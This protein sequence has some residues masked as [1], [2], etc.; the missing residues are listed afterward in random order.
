MRFARSIHFKIKGGKETELKNVF[1]KEVVPLLRKQTGFLEEVT[2]I[3]PKG[4][5]YI[6]LWDDAKNA[7]TYKTTTYPQVLAKL[8][9]FIEGTPNVETYEMASSYARL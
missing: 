8:T 6:S 1:E 9:P 2:L 7:D 3:S 4:A 5:H